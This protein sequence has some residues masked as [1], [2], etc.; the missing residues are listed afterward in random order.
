[1]SI[2]PDLSEDDMHA[3]VDDALTGDRRLEIERIFAT[4]PVAARR[5]AALKAQR[6]AL[7]EALAPIAAEPMPPGLDLA[8]LLAERRR[9]PPPVSWSFRVRRVGAAVVILCIGGAAGWVLR[10]ASAPPTSGL[11]AL[12]YD[13]SIMYAAYAPDDLHPVEFRADDKAELLRWIGARLHRR[14]IAP[15][16]TASGFRFMGGRLLPTPQGPAGMFMYDDDHGARICIFLRPMDS[17]ATMAMTQDDRGVTKGFTWS[18]QG[19]GYG[20]VGPAAADNLHPIANEARRQMN[21]DV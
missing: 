17:T 3:Y 6:T 7:R 8:H 11:A 15:D 1:M 9:A 19:M 12:G 21:Q 14:V 2:E 4:D 20:I 16:L 10:G 18:A 13:A 5:V